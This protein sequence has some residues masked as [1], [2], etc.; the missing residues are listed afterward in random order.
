MLV[1]EERFAEFEKSPHKA[2]FIWGAIC[3]A[4]F[5]DTKA[6]PLVPWNWQSLLTDPDVFVFVFLFRGPSLS[7]CYDTHVIGVPCENCGLGA[8]GESHGVMSLDVAEEC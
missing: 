3:F 7:I 1:N 4:Q 8:V 2:H 6:A 5:L